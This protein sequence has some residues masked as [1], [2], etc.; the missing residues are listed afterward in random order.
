MGLPQGIDFRLTSAF[1]TDPTNCTF[2]ISASGNDYPF[3]TPQG[4]TVGWETANNSGRNRN[5]SNDPRLAGFQFSAADLSISKFRI[6][7][8]STGS[9]SINLAAG[10]G[11]YSATTKVEFFDGTTSLG[12]ACNGSTGGANKFFDAAGNIWTAAAWVSSNVAVTDTFATT[13]FR[14]AVG[15]GSNAC[16]IAHLFIQSSGG[17]GF[18]PKFRKN[19]S[20]IGGRVGSR[21]AWTM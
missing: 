6:D 18:A 2:E 14:A 5:A 4:V 9:Y 11:S 3:T 21:Q 7:L 1:V 8:P 17:G 15:N 19:L 10:D 20:M 16:A 13:I 12:V